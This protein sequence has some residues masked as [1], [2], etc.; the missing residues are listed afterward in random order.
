V[1]ISFNNKT[2]TG[3]SCTKITI[4]RLTRYNSDKPQTKTK[5]KC[6]KIVEVRAGGVKRREDKV[7]TEEIKLPMTLLKS[8][9]KVCRVVQVSYALIVEPVVDACCSGKVQFII[10]ITIGSVPLNFDVPQ[11]L[12]NAPAHTCFEV[13]T[14]PMFDLRKKFSLTNSKSIH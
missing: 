14:A 5:S 12:L 9:A 2:S 7:H 3:I 8:N 1:T 11:K 13:P 6:E 10:P 4:N